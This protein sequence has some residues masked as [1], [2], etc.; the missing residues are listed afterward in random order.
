MPSPL[1]ALDAS[2]WDEPTTG[3]GLYTRCLASALEGEGAALEHFGARV[4]GAHPRGEMGSSAYAITRLPSLL[5]ASPARI[6]HALGNFNLPLVRLPGKAYV[7]TVHDLI[8]LMLRETASFSFRWQ[9]RIWLGHS[10]K[11]ADRIICVSG[12]TRDDLVDRFPDAASKVSVVYN[13][14]DHVDPGQLSS[15]EE[16]FLRALGLPEN[17][18]LYAG[19][20]DLRKNVDLVLDACERLHTRGRRATLVLVGQ[21]WFG[22]GRVE[23]RIS[24]LRRR[25]LDVRALG[26]QSAAVFYALMRRAS[27]FVFPSRYE[28]FGLPPLEAMRLGVPTLVSH[29]GAL[30]EIC[31]DAA[32]QVD[33]DD[34]EGLSQVLERLLLSPEERQRWSERGRQHAEAFTWKRAARETLALYES[35]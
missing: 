21:S 18:A 15:E 10:V 7:L 11:L 1:I 24:R 35:L 5:S 20:L 19:S 6:F 8:P 33:P 2:L 27:V 25:G 9:F 12:R 32:L 13:G 26:Y 31:G 4:S 14:V 17:F 3:I 22:S 30:P 23:E 34:A 28:G 16:S 29:A